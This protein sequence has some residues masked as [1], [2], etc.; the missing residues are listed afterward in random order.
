MSKN[1]TD[2]ALGTKAQKRE[3][4]SVQVSNNFFR[5]VI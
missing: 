1:N 5:T 3:E 2:Q 4:P